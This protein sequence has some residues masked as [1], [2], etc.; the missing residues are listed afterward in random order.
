MGLPHTRNN[1]IFLSL[2]QYDILDIT[3]GTL[4]HE[5]AHVS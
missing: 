3:P 5:K 4:C 2:N 1:V